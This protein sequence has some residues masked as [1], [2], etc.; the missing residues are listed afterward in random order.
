M[1]SASGVHCHS[2]LLTSTGR[3]DLTVEF[4]D[5]VYIMEFKC[6]Q[7]SKEAMEQIKEKKYA[8]RFLHTGRRIYLVG[9]NFSTEKRNIEDWEVEEASSA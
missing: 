6:D 4:A 3:I 9:I 2:E 7:S 5:R 1:V 8:E